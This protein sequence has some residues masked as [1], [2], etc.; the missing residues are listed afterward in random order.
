MNVSELIKEY[1]N[2]SSL[3]ALG[4]KYGYTGQTIKKYLEKEGVKIRSQKEQNKF[5]P[6]NQRKY[7]INDNY[8]DN[9]DDSDKAY[10]IGFL[11][12]DGCVMKDGSIRI[13]LSSVDKEILQKIQ[14]VLETNYPIRDSMTKDGFEVSTFVFRSAKIREK[15][16]EY[17]VVHNKTYSFTFPNSLPQK[18]II[19][20]IRG[21]WDGDGSVHYSNGYP[22][23]SLCSYQKEFLEKVLE[24]LEKDYQIPKV[25]LYK[26]KESNT[27]Y[28]QYSISS[29]QKLYEAFYRV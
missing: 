28:F 20:F 7:I 5:S 1:E 9:I 16:S 25:K 12:A 8:L 24:I 10:L 3:A 2:G 22:R 6:Q 29:S 26:K 14:N 19:D 15:L 17:N 13:A 21:Y 4:R 11:A 23:T 27:W 18:Y